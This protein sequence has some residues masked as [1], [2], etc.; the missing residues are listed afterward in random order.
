M[1]RGSQSVYILTSVNYISIAKE[2]Y[3]KLNVCLQLRHSSPALA[4]PFIPNAPEERC[5]QTQRQ[6]GTKKERIWIK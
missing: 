6:P 5:Q 2:M 1:S 3:N 4:R